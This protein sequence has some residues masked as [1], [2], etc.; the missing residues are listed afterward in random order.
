MLQAPTHI[1]SLEAVD[2]YQGRLWMAWGLSWAL[3]LSILSF[4]SVLPFVVIP[5]GW[6]ERWCT[7]VTTAFS[8]C[9][10][11]ALLCTRPIIKGQENLPTKRGYLVISNH[12]SWLDI[13]LLIYSTYSLGISKKE[14]IYAPFFGIAGWICGAIYFD[15]KDKNARKKVID[16]AISM[17]SRSANLH[18]FPEGTR[19]RNGR[20]GPAHMRLIEAA[21][22]AGIPIVPV[23][24]AGTEQI[25]PNDTFAAYPF[26]TPVVQ[27]GQ[28]VYC[29]DP[30][31]AGAQ[32][33][34]AWEQVLHMARSLGADS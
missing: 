11:Y 8:W 32:A 34:Q 2:K 4:F 9:C 17:M 33:A 1:R 16:E 18:L 21:C 10:L 29:N 19:S 25:L 26:G 28:A 24:L 3:V 27:I 15:R 31:Q 6:R 20:I 14:V 30:T 5:R 23:A 22:Q 7:P 12:R 13:P